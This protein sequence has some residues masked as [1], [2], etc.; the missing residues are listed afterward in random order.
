MTFEGSVIRRSLLLLSLIPAI[1]GCSSASTASILPTGG[2]PS[3]GR[4]SFELSPPFKTAP[5]TGALVTGEVPAAVMASATADLAGRTGLDPATFTTIRAEQAMWPDGSLG[6]RVPGQMYIQ[7]VTPGYW[8]VLEAGGKS[9]D[10]RATETGL[11][12]LCEQLIPPP[13]AS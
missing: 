12:R 11:V 3:G 13:S 10:Y 9:Y 2:P 7:V 6:C 8:I 4:P 5:A 1:V